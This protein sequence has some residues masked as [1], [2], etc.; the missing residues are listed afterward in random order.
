MVCT[1]ILGQKTEDNT[2]QD[3]IT[4]AGKREQERNQGVQVQLQENF[5]ARFFQKDHFENEVYL[6]RPMTLDTCK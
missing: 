2:A 5:E 3:E 6:S 1:S 4:E